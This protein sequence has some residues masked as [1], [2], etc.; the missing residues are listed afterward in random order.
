LLE[1]AANLSQVARFLNRAP[2]TL[3]GLFHCHW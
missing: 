1:G 3:S 2:S